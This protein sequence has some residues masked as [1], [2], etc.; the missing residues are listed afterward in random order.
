[1]HPS[2]LNV[3]TLNRPE[4]GYGACLDRTGGVPGVQKRI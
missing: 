3:G 4:D 1:M 2:D